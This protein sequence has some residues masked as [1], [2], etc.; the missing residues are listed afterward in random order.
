MYEELPFCLANGNAVTLTAAS[1]A[2]KIAD[3]IVS[4]KGEVG[5]EDEEEIFV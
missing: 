4:Y 5:V 1:T 3:L 2:V